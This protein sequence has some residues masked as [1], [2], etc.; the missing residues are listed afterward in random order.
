MC[1]STIKISYNTYKPTNKKDL[2]N[3]TYYYGTIQTKELNVAY[4]NSTVLKDSSLFAI[5]Q[6]LDL[7]IDKNKNY[8]FNEKRKGVAFF[9]TISSEAI[10]NVT[11][12]NDNKLNPIESE[13]YT[14]FIGKNST[15]LISK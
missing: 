4:A 13:N 1:N 8:W 6:Y 11:D 9:K 2:Y 7:L 12:S 10:E 14:L 3:N 15:E 5:K